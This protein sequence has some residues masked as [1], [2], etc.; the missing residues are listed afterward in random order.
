MDLI[1]IE[2]LYENCIYSSIAHAIFVL[3]NPLFSY[4]QS[5]DTCNY[6]I[7]F[8]TSR[9]TISFDL[10]RKI[11]V[12]TFRDEDSSYLRYYPDQIKAMDFL[13]DASEKVKVFAKSE[14]M[15]YLYDTIEDYT[16]PVITAAFWLDNNK[17][18][19]GENENLFFKNGGYILKILSN[20][21]A[22]LKEYWE[23]QYYFSESE[24]ELVNMLFQSFVQ[25][26]KEVKLDRSLKSITK[27][28]GYAEMLCSL[29][30]IGITIKFRGIL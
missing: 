11:V 12:G 4:E 3:K 8:G 14:S 25:N 7:H 26:K 17:I 28:K 16:G 18:G 29:S 24:N 5:W 6:S 20:K 21:N 23:K 27:E 9:G 10:Q 13:K 1:S 19:F 2:T 22:D 15:M 30:E